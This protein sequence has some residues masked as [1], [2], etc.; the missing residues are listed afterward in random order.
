MQAPLYL[1]PGNRDNNTAMRSAFADKSY[2]PDEGGFLHYAV[3]DH[4][5]RLVAIDSTLPGEHMG[6]FCPARQAWLEAALSDRPDQPT[7]LFI[8]HPPFDIGDHYVGGYRRPGEAAALAGV[9]AATRRSRGCC[10]A[11]ST[12]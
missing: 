12:A 3:D 9:S 4:A 7:V 2:L 8:H 11:M 10:A 6:V 1:I 5:V